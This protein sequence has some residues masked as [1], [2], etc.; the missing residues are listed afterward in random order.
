MTSQNLDYIFPGSLGFD[1]FCLELAFVSLP[2]TK[3]TQEEGNSTGELFPSDWS[4]GMS[5]GH[6]P[7]C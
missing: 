5:L 2:Q 1:Y 6:S 7:N 4:M 3:I